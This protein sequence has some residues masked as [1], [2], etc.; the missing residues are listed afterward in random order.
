MVMGTA[1]HLKVSAGFE[2]VKNFDTYDRASKGV[3]NDNNRAMTFLD[4]ALAEEPEFDRDGRKLGLDQGDYE[5]LEDMVRFWFQTVGEA[6]LKQIETIIAVEEPH[7]M[8]I[9]RHHIRFTPDLVAKLYFNDHPTVVD[10]KTGKPQKGLDW[11]QLDTQFAT[12]T[13]GIA[14]IYGGIDQFIHSF[15]DRDVPPGFGHRSELTDTG[16]PRKSDVLARM[17]EPTQYCS[18]VKTPIT[19]AEVQAYTIDLIETLQDIDA[20]YATNRWP[21]R[22]AIKIPPMDCEGCWFFAP[23]RAERMGQP[24]LTQDQAR[25]KYLVRGTPEWEAVQEGKRALELVDK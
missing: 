4:A 18:E 21:R 9:G 11:V 19:P 16:K 24:P 6:F 1:F 15:Q 3:R 14:G 13:V 23:C 5:L 17:Q 25:A 10:L 12:Y 7:Y 8:T 20:S 22:E 2:A